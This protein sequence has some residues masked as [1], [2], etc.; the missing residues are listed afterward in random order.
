MRGIFL[1]TDVLLG[2]I[3]V[4]QGFRRYSTFGTF[5][6]P[7]VSSN[8]LRLEEASSTSDDIPTMRRKSWL[9]RSTGTWVVIA[10]ASIT[11][12][13][14]RP[15][16]SDLK[17]SSVISPPFDKHDHR[18]SRI[19]PFWDKTGSS[20]IMQQFIRVSNTFLRWDVVFLS[21]LAHP[22]HVLVRDVLR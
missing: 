15:A 21:T 16:Q 5:A 12:L 11:T 9:S 19:I 13:C 3:G 20:T 14:F 1:V 18:G 17:S 22:C 6:L 8:E 7:R 4:K 10:I 2:Y